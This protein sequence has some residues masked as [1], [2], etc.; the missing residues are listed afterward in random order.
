MHAQINNIWSFSLISWTTLMI[1]Q[2]VSY[3]I[4]HRRLCE[5]IAVTE[6][7]TECVANTFTATLQDV[8]VKALKINTRRNKNSFIIGGI[9][10]SCLKFRCT[11]IQGLVFNIW[12]YSGVVHHDYWRSKILNL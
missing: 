8:V 12:P 5:S 4:V 1:K 11:V 6:H 3:T 2:N 10:N 9:L 7:L